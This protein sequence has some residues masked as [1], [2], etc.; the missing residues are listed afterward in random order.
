MEEKK[1]LRKFGISL[2][3]IFGI[4]GGIFSWR[5]SGA[6]V[7]IYGIAALL[8]VPGLIV[9][10]ILKPVE[11]GWMAF[12]GALNWI[13]TRIIL[14]TLFYTIITLIGLIWRIINRDPFGL[15]FDRNAA[16]YWAPRKQNPLD[17]ERFERQY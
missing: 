1:R 7:Y 10:M 12:A 11:K 14:G 2:G 13:M 9:P 17:K 4:I 8:F 5:E 15:R 3:I 6:A 16:S